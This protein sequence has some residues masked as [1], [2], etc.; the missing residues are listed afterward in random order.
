MKRVKAEVYVTLKVGKIDENLLQRIY[1]GFLL[2][3]NVTKEQGC[4][5]LVKQ[6]FCFID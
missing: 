6:I 1:N 3:L 5:S 4:I 2:F